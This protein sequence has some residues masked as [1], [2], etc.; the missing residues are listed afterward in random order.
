MDT[1]TEIL[2]L[3]Q[4]FPGI[5][6]TLG[7]SSY[8]N[9]DGVTFRNTGISIGG[10]TIE[11]GGRRY[12]TDDPHA[13]DTMKQNDRELFWSF[14]SD[15]GKDS[16][17]YREYA[18]EKLKSAK[19]NLES[20][21]PES[22]QCTVINQATAFSDFGKYCNQKG[23]ANWLQQLVNLGNPLFKMIILESANVKKLLESID[24]LEKGSAITI[25]VNIPSEYLHVMLENIWD[26]VEFLKGLSQIGYQNVLT[27]CLNIPLERFRVFLK[28]R[29]ETIEVIKGFLHQGD[30]MPLA[31][32]EALS[33]QQIDILINHRYDAMESMKALK[34]LGYDAPLNLI[35]SITDTQRKDLFDKRYDAFELMTFFHNTGIQNPWQKYL[36]MPPTTLQLVLDKRYDATEIM[37]AL[38]NR[39]INDPLAHLE[40]LGTKA[41]ITI[42]G[43]RYEYVNRIKRGVSLEMEFKPPTK[44]R[45]STT[46][47]AYSQGRFDSEM[48]HAKRLSQMTA[49]QQHGTFA[50]PVS[51]SRPILDR[52]D[53]KCPAAFLCPITQELMEFPVLCTL[54]GQSYEKRAVKLWL[55]KHGT[56]PLTRAA[57]AAGQSVDSVLFPN[58]SLQEA[59]ESFCQQQKNGISPQ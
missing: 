53:E 29:Y 22:L 39:G 48:E 31:T 42:F 2:K 38:Q 40:K 5:S 13:V 47:D 43:N 16:D 35:F 44:D 41:M 7:G 21:E 56:S 12:H 55:E 4:K 24:S 37:K 11:F 10:G 34:K 9:A 52:V 23:Y 14:C 57:L 3:M 26:S 50:S 25:L 36:S 58:R 19:I 27:L 51:E 18:L 33:T 17:L 46:K 1:N 28:N 49:L 54:D 30:R 32:C 6:M 8:I 59:I 45:V 15:R 20:I